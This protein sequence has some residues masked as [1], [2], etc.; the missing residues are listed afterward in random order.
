MNM[1]SFK[2]NFRIVSKQKI[3]ELLINFIIVSFA[4]PF[5]TYDT[6]IRCITHPCTGSTTRGSLIEF[7]FKSHDFTTYTIDYWIFILAFIIVY[8]S[9]NFLR[10]L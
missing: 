8:M 2:S 4:V 7:L 6:G 5:I 9:I 3:I 10:R 1:K